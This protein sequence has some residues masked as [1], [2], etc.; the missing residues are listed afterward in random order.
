MVVGAFARDLHLHYGAGVPIQR[1]T[2]DVDFA[3]A[4]R[5]WDGF[6]ELR[7]RLVASGR[8]R[9]SEGRWHRLVHANWV[10]IDLL[11]FGSIESRDRT[12]VW[13]PDG[14]VVMDV[15]GFQEAL[16]SADQVLLPG[17]VTLPVVCLPGLAL[18]KIIAWEDRH[19]CSPQKDAADL[20][21]ILR[22]YLSIPANTQRLWTQF[23]EWTAAPDFDYE[24]SGARMVGYDIRRLIGDEGLGRL[25]RILAA[26]LDQDGPGELPYEM[27]RRFPENAFALLKSLYSGLTL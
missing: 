20:N 11:P 4:V 8:F 15:Y 12:I 7:T 1:G 2:E 6:E 9:A 24:H 5:S 23:A 21:L 26:Q 16:E 17:N 18:L 22:N 19:R 27:N 3:L 13:P 25:Q 14:N 10:R